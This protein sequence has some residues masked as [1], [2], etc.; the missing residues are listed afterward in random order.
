MGDSI[1]AASPPNDG[2]EWD[3]QCAR[4]GS[5]VVHVQC[6]DC[7]WDGFCGDDDDP[8]LPRAIRC[9]AC[10]G[11]GGWPACCSDAEWCNAHPLPGRESVERGAVEWFVVREVSRG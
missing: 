11:A 8:F 9:G 4:C 1:I 7:W 2:R 10:N 3:A 6:Y 5:S